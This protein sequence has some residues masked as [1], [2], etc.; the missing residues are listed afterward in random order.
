MV[1]E[2]TLSII[3]PDAVGK[4]HIGEIISRFEKSGLRVIA[5]KMK[6]LSKPEAE[7]FYAVHRERPFFNSLVTFMTEGPI[8]AAVLEK[9]NAENDFRK[10]IGATN[11]A[12]AEAGTIRKNFATSI[13]RNAVHGSDSDEN[14]QI[15]AGF[16]FSGLE[17]F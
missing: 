16:H 9:D 10:L 2:R 8:V 1:T 11:P 6:H 14:V 12:N 15:E 3:K 13:E 17:R 5:A 4:N 7:G